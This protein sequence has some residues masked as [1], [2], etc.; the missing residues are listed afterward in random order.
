MRR[1]ACPVAGD[2]PL[3]VRANARPTLQIVLNLMLNAEQ[4]IGYAPGWRIDLRVCRETPMAPRWSYRI[5][6]AAMPRMPIARLP[7]QMQGETRRDWAWGCWPH[8]G[9]PNV[10]VAPSSSGHPRA[11][12]RRFGLPALYAPRQRLSDSIE[13]NGAL[14]R[15]RPSV[16]R[17]WADRDAEA[18]DE[19]RPTEVEQSCR[20]ALVAAG[21]LE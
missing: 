4:A 18:I 13:V 9:W 17:A 14:V 11:P 12:S 19:C 1:S 3:A 5:T 10:K 6:A 16:Q 21:L 8:A 15:A 7:L 2:E 20:T